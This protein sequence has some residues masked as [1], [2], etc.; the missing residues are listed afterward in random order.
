METKECFKCHLIKPLSEYYIHKQMGDG[1]LN[2]CKECAKKD[3]KLKYEENVE[4]ED[5]VEKERKRGRTKYAKYKY[6]NKVQHPENRSTAVYLKKQGV[7]LTGK[8]IHHWNYNFKNDVFI[9]N[10]RAHSLVHKYI[11]FDQ[12]T[13]SFKRKIDMCLINSK[14]FHFEIIKDIFNE[15]NVNYEIDTYPLPI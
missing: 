4:S 7:D 3:V 2:K 9:L 14:E 13:N 12:E 10:R 6:V 15:N 11:I 1:H 8:E 5:Y